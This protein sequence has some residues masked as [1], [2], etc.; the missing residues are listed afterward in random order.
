M[1]GCNK[2]DKTVQNL[3]TNKL[4]TEDELGKLLLNP[5]LENHKILN[6]VFVGDEKNIFFFIFVNYL[7]SLVS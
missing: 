2:N 5:R 4:N 7:Y 1:C 3:L 6:V